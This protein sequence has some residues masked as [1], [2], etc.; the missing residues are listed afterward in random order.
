MKRLN[1]INASPAL[2]MIVVH[3]NNNVLQWVDENEHVSDPVEN[4]VVLTTEGV[5]MDEVSQAAALDAGS[6]SIHEG[7]TGRCETK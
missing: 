2:K 7:F 5:R 1:R 6:I 4:T 3:L